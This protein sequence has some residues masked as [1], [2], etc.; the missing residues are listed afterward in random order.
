MNLDLNLKPYKKVLFL[1]TSDVLVIF[2]KKN[3][4]Y[5][6]LYIFKPGERVE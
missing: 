1:N 3:A 6:C 2:Q 4:Q 5:S